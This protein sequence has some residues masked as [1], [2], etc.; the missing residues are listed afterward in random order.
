[1]AVATNKRLAPTQ[2]LLNHFGWNDYFSSI[3]CSDSKNITRT[4]GEMIEEIIL[5]NNRKFKDAYFIGDTVND[6]ISANRKKLKFIKADYG[7]GTN[8]DWSNV[9]IFRSIK[10][11][12]EINDLI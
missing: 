5:E 3:E 9:Q 7:Y 2:K 10:K 1:M 11:F 4:K 6:G 12:S 8:Q